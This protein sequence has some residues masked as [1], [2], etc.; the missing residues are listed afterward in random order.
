MWRLLSSPRVLARITATID[1]VAHCER[2]SAHRLLTIT[3]GLGL[4]GQS[5]DQG[6]TPSS[7]VNNHGLT[8]QL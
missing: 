3:K 2:R 8:T 4:S 1:L 7:V 5:T 6:S